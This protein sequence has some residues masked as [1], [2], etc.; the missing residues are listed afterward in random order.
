MLNN[1]SKPFLSEVDTERGEVPGKEGIPPGYCV[2]I[3]YWVD[4]VRC[5]GLLLS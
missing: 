2:A 5:R 3:L 1:F 4:D